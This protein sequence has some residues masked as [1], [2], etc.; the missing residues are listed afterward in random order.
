MSG[1]F[2]ETQCRSVYMQSWRQTW[3]CGLSPA[4]CRLAPTVK[5]T[6]L[7]SGCE[8]IQFRILSFL[9]S[10]SVNNV[11]KLLQLLGFVQ[12]WTFLASP[13]SICTHHYDA[14]VVLYLQLLFSSSSEERPIHTGLDSSLTTQHSCRF[15]ATIWR[16]FHHYSFTGRWSSFKSFIRQH[17]SH[18]RR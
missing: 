12:E 5:Q 6:G 2:F 11:S 14:A 8:L 15:S 18:P 9:Q 17:A 10:K 1:V 3:D 4:K 7:E 13:L 16:Q